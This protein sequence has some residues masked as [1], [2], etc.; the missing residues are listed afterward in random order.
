MMILVLVNNELVITFK[1]L[2]FIDYT[3]DLD[4]KLVI[5]KETLRFDQLVEYKIPF[6]IYDILPGFKSTFIDTAS[7]TINYSIFKINAPRDVM[8]HVPKIFIRGIET[9]HHY[10]ESCLVRYQKRMVIS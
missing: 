4:Y 2:N 6:K 8:V 9:I 3:A 1:N 7:S 5:N 10:M